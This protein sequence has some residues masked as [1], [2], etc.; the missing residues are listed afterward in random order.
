MQDSK[1]DCL[2]KA[3]L[4]S[5][6]F[7]REKKTYRKQSA[8]PEELRCGQLITVISFLSTLVVMW[9]LCSSTLNPSS[10]ITVSLGPWCISVL[11]VNISEMQEKSIK[12][13]PVRSEI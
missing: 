13:L 2:S 10:N 6:Q 4:V 1:G 7:V 5:S 12:P 8:K 3:R 11:F 9:L